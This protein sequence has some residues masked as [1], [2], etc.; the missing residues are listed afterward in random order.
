MCWL[1]EQS[2]VGHLSFICQQESS[3]CAWV[4]MGLTSVARAWLGN[5]FPSSDIWALRQAGLNMIRLWGGA[6]V[7][8]DAFYD[9]CDEAGI[10]VRRDCMKL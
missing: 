5:S 2:Y 1:L 4:R 9:A 6:A 8:R 7:A 3:A 10:L